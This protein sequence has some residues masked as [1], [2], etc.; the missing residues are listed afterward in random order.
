MAP[1][2]SCSNM[3]CS[4]AIITSSLWRASDFARKFACCT[5]AGDV[6]TASDIASGTQL[7]AHLLLVVDFHV[8]P[9]VT[10]AAEAAALA[11]PPTLQQQVGQH[12]GRFSLQYRFRPLVRVRC[13]EAS[14]S[15]TVHAGCGDPG[16]VMAHSEF[17]PASNPEAQ[18]RTVSF[19][20]AAGVRGDVRRAGRKRRLHPQGGPHA[21]APA[22]AAPRVTDQR[23]AAAAAACLTPGNRSCKGS[24]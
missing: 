20:V 14:P 6:T 19:V 11:A 13:R 18:R 8:L 9:D 15:D 21:L 7:L 2:A 16:S 24:S 10:D 17:C 3:S 23:G 1:I 4:K 22:P 12:T 5:G